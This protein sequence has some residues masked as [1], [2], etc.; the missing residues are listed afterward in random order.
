MS[1]QVKVLVA[2]TEQLSLIFGTHMM[3]E[4]N[5]ASRVV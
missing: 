2:K 5:Q 3:K 1:Q 4:E